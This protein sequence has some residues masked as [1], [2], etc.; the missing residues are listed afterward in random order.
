MEVGFCHRIQPPDPLSPLPS[1]VMMFDENL[2]GL[3]WYVACDH[4]AHDDTLGWCILDVEALL[5]TMR[6]KS[7]ATVL[8]KCKLKYYRISECSSPPSSPEGCT[9]KIQLLSVPQ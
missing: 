4:V 2:S 5:H 1:C 7:T 6:F 3:E 8:L 9:I